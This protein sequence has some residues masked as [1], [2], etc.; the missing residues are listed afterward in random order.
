MSIPTHF[1]LPVLRRAGPTE[2][3]R[4]EVVRAL[5][6]RLKGDDW[7]HLEVYSYRDDRVVFLVERET[8]LSLAAGVT[9]PVAKEK[10]R[11]ILAATTKKHFY[12]M[13]EAAF[14]RINPPPKPKTIQ[15]VNQLTK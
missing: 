12:E 10:L 5:R 7:R 8:G 4:W 2:P 15:L 1:L 9:L 11:V 3:Y 14:K 6:H 13:L